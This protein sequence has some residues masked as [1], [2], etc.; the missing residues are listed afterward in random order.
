M[1]RAGLLTR[2]PVAVPSCP[3]VAERIERYAKLN[4]ATQGM[5]KCSGQRP[6]VTTCPGIQMLHVFRLRARNA[7]P[8]SKRAGPTPSCNP[9]RLS[10][11]R[12]ATWGW[13]HM[14]CAQHRAR[15]HQSSNMFARY[16][17]SAAETV[18]GSNLLVAN[19][20]FIE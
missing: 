13:P 11:V 2:V 3:R 9:T 4:A 16:F 18:A 6:Y 17:R 15:A 19:A 20:S 1:N 7:D 10:V 5:R 8:H 14:L 12:G